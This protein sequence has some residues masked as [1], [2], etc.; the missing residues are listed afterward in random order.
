MAVTVSQLAAALRITKDPTAP[1]AE[2]RLGILT[3]ILN[4]AQAEV[5][6]RA[7]DAPAAVADQA[8]VQLAAYIYDSPN[9]GSR[10]S[11]ANSWEN[12]GA[13]VILRRYLLRRGVVVAP[14]GQVQ[15]ASGGAGGG[16][17]ATASVDPEEVRRIARAL[18]TSIVQP[19]SAFSYY[20]APTI[21]AI[22]DVTT[23]AV[24]GTGG[25]YVVNLLTEFDAPSGIQA[26]VDFV[27]EWEGYFEVELKSSS[28]LQIALRTTHE[29]SGKTLVHRRTIYQDALAGTRATVPMQLFN[30]RSRVE[31]GTFGGVTVTAED[32]A[33][34]S[35]ISY[36]LEFTI[37]T[38]KTQTRRAGEISYLSFRGLET[39]SYQLRQALVE[40]HGGTGGAGLSTQDVQALITGAL[41]NFPTLT[42]AQVN[43][44]IQAALVGLTPS[45]GGGGLT[46]SQVNTLITAAL[47]A[48]STTAQ[49]QGRLLP[50]GGSNGQ[51]VSISGNTPVWVARPTGGSTGTASHDP[52]LPAWGSTNLTDV[53][54]VQWLDANRETLVLKWTPSVRLQLDALYRGIY[55]QLEALE[56]KT[57]DLLLGDRITNWT[58]AENATAGGVTASVTSKNLAQVKVSAFGPKFNNPN[59][60][61]YVRLPHGTDVRRVRLAF[62]IREDSNLVPQQGVPIPP[63]TEWNL[64][65]S[66]MFKLADPDSNPTYDYYSV[67]LQSPDGELESVEV[68]L[69][70]RTKFG[71]TLFDGTNQH[72]LDAITA[73]DS[74]F[75]SHELQIEALEQKTADLHAGNTPAA[76]WSNAADAAAGAVAVHSATTWTIAQ[77]RAATW[78][79]S[80]A[81]PRGHIAVRVPRNTDMGTVRIRLTETGSSGRVYDIQGTAL[82]PVTGGSRAKDPDFEYYYFYEGPLSHVAAIVVQLT[83]SS[84]HVGRTRFLGTPE[85]L[86]LGLSDFN[87]LFA[88]LYLLPV[89]FGANGTFLGIAGGKPKW[90]KPT[91]TVSPSDIGTKTWA[92]ETLR[93]STF[94]DTGITV[95]PGD[96]SIVL[97]HVKDWRVDYYGNDTELDETRTWDLSQQLMIPSA[98]FGA[99][100]RRSVGDT[101]QVGT[102]ESGPIATRGVDFFLQIFRTSYDFALTATT[103]R[104]L[105][106]VDGASDDA[107]HSGTLVVRGF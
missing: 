35:V 94:I 10:G 59:G 92:R 1:V 102:R 84:S 55:A 95:N 52:R 93:V 37:N 22:A 107:R 27:T 98:E 11:F 43:A 85:G 77:A 21:P 41:T 5:S 29:F 76:G 101:A 3:R 12:S 83:G 30:S 81:N 66:A 70:S 19:R 53:L 96:Q 73:L 38:R 18:I 6:A 67:G 58:T 105:I 61:M 54:S 82:T 100:P 34:P 33:Q 63:L 71:R 7:P 90:S 65:G 2:P 26:G 45:G 74:R 103:N 91:S 4:F 23:Q 20:A 14:S 79:Q 32:I 87:P 88:S 57:T 56:R 50:A 86:S 106:A 72:T 60:F 62:E 42:V 39:V 75:E 28:N 17:P 9:A 89:P 104:L 97:I 80:I 31:P 46:T 36:A 25:V 16:V 64:P 40:I 49:L 69:T 24:A 44:L 13:P 15:Q 8:V 99:I 51:F 78:S 68:Q 47:V 48:Y